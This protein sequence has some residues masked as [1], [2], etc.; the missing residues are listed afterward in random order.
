M[1]GE[2]YLDFLEIENSF[3][4]INEFTLNEQNLINKNL[5]KSYYKI[6]ATTLRNNKLERLKDKNNQDY[7]ILVEVD[8]LSFV[9]EFKI[10]KYN[11]M[12]PLPTLD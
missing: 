10:I 9:E 1:N 3:N 11:W 6:Y 4:N 12:R 8:Q 5:S 7:Y 2:D